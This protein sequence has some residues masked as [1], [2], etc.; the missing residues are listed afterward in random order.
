MTKNNIIIIVSL[1][2]TVIVIIIGVSWAIYFT[3]NNFQ[4]ENSPADILSTDSSFPTILTTATV[5]EQLKQLDDLRLSMYGY[6]KPTENEDRKQLE[7][8][9]KR[10][11]N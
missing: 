8:L 9:D 11:H 7:E 2:S 3:T 10:R 5:M 6:K 1:V 4:E